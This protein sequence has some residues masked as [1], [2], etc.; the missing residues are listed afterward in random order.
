M[1]NLMIVAIAF[2][3]NVVFVGAAEANGCLQDENCGATVT[4]AECNWYVRTVCSYGGQ[5]GWNYNCSAVG[6]PQC[7]LEKPSDTE[8]FFPGTFGNERK[9]QDFYMG[10]AMDMLQMEMLQGVDIRLYNMLQSDKLMG[11]LDC[12]LV[13]PVDGTANPVSCN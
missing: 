13:N 12:I 4:Y 2:I 3:A 8:E 6:E 7:L 10:N 5:T 1:K 11:E 9:Y